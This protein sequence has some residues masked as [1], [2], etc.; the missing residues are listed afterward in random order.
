MPKEAA[1]GID[2]KLEET[3]KKKARN[4]AMLGHDKSSHFTGKRQKKSKQLPS[5]G[6][7]PLTFYQRV[8]GSNTAPQERFCS[9]IDE[10]TVISIT[11]PMSKGL[12]GI[13]RHNQKTDRQ[14]D[15]QID[16]QTDRQTDR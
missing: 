7:D 9:S 16:R 6:F 12:P 1:M 3:E 5:Q 13:G 2:K 14:I 11:D 15:R 10:I 4:T 8:H